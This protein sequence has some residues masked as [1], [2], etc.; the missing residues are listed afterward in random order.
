MHHER[1]L[2]QIYRKV[3]WHRNTCT[4]NLGTVLIRAVT[5]MCS[6][7]LSLVR[8]PSLHDFFN[9]RTLPELP[10][11]PFLPP[12]CTKYILKITP[13]T[14]YSFILSS[15]IPSHPRHTP[16]SSST[17]NGRATDTPHTNAPTTPSSCDAKLWN[18]PRL[19]LLLCTAD[20]VGS[21][22]TQL[23]RLYF[24]GAAARVPHIDL[25]CDAATLLG[26]K[27]TASLWFELQFVALCFSNSI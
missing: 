8:L 2:R 21:S 23:D 26:G 4:A 20:L 24:L 17:S 1:P 18:L 3:I 16:P 7:D 5:T 12:R 22:P 11:S 10:I 6:T 27:I 9:H 14:F 15:L 25:L 13:R 19:S